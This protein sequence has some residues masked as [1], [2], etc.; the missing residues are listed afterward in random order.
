MCG[1]LDF[2]SKT[3]EGVKSSAT[4]FDEKPSEHRWRWPRIFY[5]HEKFLRIY[6]LS[7]SEINYRLVKWFNGEFSNGSMIFAFDIVSP[8]DKNEIS[9]IFG[10]YL[11]GLFLWNQQKKKLVWFIDIDNVKGIKEEDKG[12]K[13]MLYHGLNKK[14][15]VIH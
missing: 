13:I 2:A 6:S 15:K 4:Y 12:I 5:G 3:A 8:K 10:V 11:E 14:E 9:S 1:V 7:D